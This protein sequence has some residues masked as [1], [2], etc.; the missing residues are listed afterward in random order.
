MAPPSLAYL[1]SFWRI[2][3]CL[4]FAPGGPGPLSP[5]EV[6]SEF[7]VSAFELTSANYNGASVAACARKR[8]S[9][10]SDSDLNCQI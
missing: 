1:A 7:R 4:N 5:L 6:E 3:L 2:F 9:R 8:F 10:T